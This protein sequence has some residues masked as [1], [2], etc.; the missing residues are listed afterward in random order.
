MFTFCSEGFPGNSFIAFTRLLSSLPPCT[1]LP[2]EF[3]CLTNLTKLHGA[4]TK[5]L[6]EAVVPS[7]DEKTIPFPCCDLRVATQATLV[8]KGFG[9]LSPAEE[10]QSSLVGLAA[11]L[12]V[13]IPGVGQR[14]EAATGQQ[15][16]QCI[17]PRYKLAHIQV[18]INYTQRQDTLHKGQSH[19]NTEDMLH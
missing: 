2:K 13:P 7:Q 5:V 3:T 1:T 6:F 15:S 17:W 4:I 11:Y 12:P 16:P 19:L 8:L 18:V 9:R 10:S 14:Q